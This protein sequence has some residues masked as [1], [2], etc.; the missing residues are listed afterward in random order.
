MIRDK[1]IDHERHQVR[2][3]GQ[4]VRVTRKEWAAFSLLVES[5]GHVVS[6]E[7]LAQHLW[8]RG[9][10]PNV[11]HPET[12]VLTALRRRLTPE[13]RWRIVNYWGIGWELIDKEKDE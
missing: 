4:W 11:D 12:R 1:G 5:Y 8:P 3:G 6:G 7:R 13:S 10:N 2:V 9:G